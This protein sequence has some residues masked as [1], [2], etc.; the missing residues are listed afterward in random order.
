MNIIHKIYRKDAHEIS[1]IFFSNENMLHIHSQI[2][3]QVFYETQITISKQ[4]DMEVL[5]IMSNIYNLYGSTPKSTKK[6]N[7]EVILDLNYRVIREATDNAKSG[8]LMYA[9]YLK[10][11]STLPEPMDRARATTNDRSLEM[12]KTFFTESSL[13]PKF[14]EHSNFLSKK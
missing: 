9:K 1:S 6:E 4:S 12:T 10:D 13:H 7:G 8:I 14:Q 3:K 11:A 5:H 2:V